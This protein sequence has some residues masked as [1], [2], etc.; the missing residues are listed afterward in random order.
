MAILRSQAAV[1]KGS[2]ESSETT[3]LNLHLFHIMYNG[4]SYFKTGP[5]SNFFL[6]EAQ[7]TMPLVSCPTFLLKID[8]WKRNKHTHKQ[9]RSSYVCSVRMCLIQF[10]H[11]LPPAV[12][13][14]NTGVEFIVV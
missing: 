12:I 5:H 9:K 1:N 14:I 11:I 6:V 13:I 10:L 3:Y 7:G 2:Y 4:Y 8:Y